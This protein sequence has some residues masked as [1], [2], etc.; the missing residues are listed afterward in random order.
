M[1]LTFEAHDLDAANASVAPALTPTGYVLPLLNGIATLRISTTI[2]V[3]TAY[4]AVAPTVIAEL[5]G[6]IR[7][8][9]EGA[10]LTNSDASADCRGQTSLG[11]RADVRNN[12]SGT[13]P[14]ARARCCLHD[15]L[16]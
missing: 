6:T 15:G 2:S 4:W 16:S 13:T 12:H 11:G 10:L 8:A 3:E 5:P 7:R 1:L 14:E 9:G